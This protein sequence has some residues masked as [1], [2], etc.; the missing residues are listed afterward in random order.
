MVTTIEQ[1]KKYRLDLRRSI[2][3]KIRQPVFYGTEAA[4]IAAERKQIEAAAQN[5]NEL[6]KDSTVQQCVAA[7][8]AEMRMQAQAGDICWPHQKRKAAHLHE[9][10]H[11]F[12][13]HKL[14]KSYKVEDLSKKDLKIIAKNYPGTR[15]N[16]RKKFITI[17]GFFVFCETEDV[18]GPNQSPASDVKILVK[19]ERRKRKNLVD[20]KFRRIS[21]LEMDAIIKNA[22]RFTLQITMAAFTGIRAGEQCAL[23][24]NDEE[25]DYV[26]F[27]R[28][29]LHIRH[30]IDELEDGSRVR[31]SYKTMNAERFIPL[32]TDLVQ[33]L[34][35]HKVSQPLHMRGGNFVFPNRFGGLGYHRQ[36]LRDGLK[37]AC[38]RAGVEP[39]TWLDLR[40]FFAS[41]CIFNTFLPA[42]RIAQMMGHKSGAFTQQFYARWLNDAERDKEIIA[43]LDALSGPRGAQ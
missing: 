22:E 18:I 26:D 11:I 28:Q 37:P 21:I 43:E 27:K 42:P 23:Q 8:N 25:I 30:G 4:A 31:G 6:D 12:Y 32:R 16:A 3:A 40:H 14:I 5:E 24:W 10:C 39:C 1:N 9:F 7:Y 35:Q 15:I 29:C 41:V 36:W 34:R 17:K 33:Q 38:E 2:K 13:D 19:G 20:K